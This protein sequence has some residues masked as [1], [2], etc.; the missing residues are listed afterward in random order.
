MNNF[1]GPWFS[2][3]DHYNAN[4]SVVYMDASNA[5]AHG[6]SSQS[7]RGWGELRLG[8]T[9]SVDQLFAGIATKLTALTEET[10]NAVCDLRHD[11]AEGGAS[12]EGQW[13]EA[14]RGSAFDGHHELR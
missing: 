6:A 8:P 10:T 3:A 5:G 7:M 11:G 12:A 2:Y 9:G 4:T 14:G 1:E 13:Q